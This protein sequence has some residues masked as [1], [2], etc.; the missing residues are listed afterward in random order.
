MRK[1]AME[2]V[3]A[4]FF[5]AKMAVREAGI[6]D[7]GSKNVVCTH[8]PYMHSM[9]IVQSSCTCTHRTL[10]G[11]FQEMLQLEVEFL[12]PLGLVQPCFAESSPEWAVV[13][14]SRGRFR[15]VWGWCWVSFRIAD[16]LMIAGFVFAWFIEARQRVT[17]QAAVGWV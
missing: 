14:F 13:V 12:K 17:I 1:L 15:V 7:S 2:V 16:F 8:T 9:H 10:V 3:N 11:A 5:C 6:L 4:R